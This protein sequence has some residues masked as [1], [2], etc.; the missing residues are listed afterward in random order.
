MGINAIVTVTTVA[1]V[2]LKSWCFIVLEMTT[3]KALKCFM[4]GKTPFD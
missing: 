1:T 4:I 2:L 3:A